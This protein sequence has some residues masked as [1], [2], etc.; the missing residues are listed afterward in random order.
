MSLLTGK[1]TSVRLHEAYVHLCWGSAIEGMLQSPALPWEP[2]YLCMDI[3][4]ERKSESGCKRDL[5]IV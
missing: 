4:Q 5:F 2:A 1:E 3:Q